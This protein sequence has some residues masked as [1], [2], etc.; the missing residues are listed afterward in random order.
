MMRSAG[1]AAN[2]RPMELLGRTAAWRSGPA[3]RAGDVLL[4]L[5]LARM[6]RRAPVTYAVSRAALKLA[7]RRMLVREA[8][9]RSQRRR[10]I[11]R[12]IVAGAVLVAAAAGTGRALGGSRP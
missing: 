7:R 5:G 3:S 9:R 4:A 12:S 1:A 6:S 8:E 10:R 11:R 2:V